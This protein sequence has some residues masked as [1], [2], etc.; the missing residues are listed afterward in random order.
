[1]RKFVLSLFPLLILAGC[2]SAGNRTYSLSETSWRFA[3]IDGASPVSPESQL[4]FEGDRI[5]ATVGCNRMVGGW[6]METGRLIAGPLASTKM[7]CPDRLDEQERAVETLLVSAPEAMLARDRL[8]LR[9]S[10]HTAVLVR[11]N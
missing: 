1:M 6:R 3:L 7:L 4:A 10:G 9:A 2:I 5:A 8:E 11:Q